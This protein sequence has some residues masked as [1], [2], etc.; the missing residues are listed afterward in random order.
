MTTN[1][2]KAIAAAAI[3]VTLGLAAWG[4]HASRHHR[5]SERLEKHVVNAHAERQGLSGKLDHIEHS[6]HSM[7]VQQAVMVEKLDQ[8]LGLD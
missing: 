3:A 2:N 5:E 4:N 7:E 1:M 6:V 8:A